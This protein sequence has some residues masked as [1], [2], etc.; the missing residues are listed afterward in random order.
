[1]N[2]LKILG[3]LS[4]ILL[5]YDGIN[6]LV[7]EKINNNNGL[8]KKAFFLGRLL[9]ILNL[10]LFSLVGLIR[11][12]STNIECFYSSA[13]KSIEIVVFMQTDIFLDS[14]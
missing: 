1:M 8:I 3:S 13:I 11:V 12:I 10:I 2:I 14:D 5:I 7:V 6:E 4:S 9:V